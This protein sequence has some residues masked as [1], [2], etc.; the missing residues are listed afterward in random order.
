MSDQSRKIEASRRRM[1]TAVEKVAVYM[2]SDKDFPPQQRPA[3]FSIDQ[4]MDKVNA[5]LKAR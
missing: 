1:L 2:S 3:S 4:I 5:S